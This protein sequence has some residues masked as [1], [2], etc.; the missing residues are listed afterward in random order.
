[1]K[2]VIELKEGVISCDEYTACANPANGIES[3]KSPQIPPTARPCEKSNTTNFSWWFFK[4]NLGH[5]A[6]PSGFFIHLGRDG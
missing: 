4:F 6:R 5:T 1:M 3:V 2:V